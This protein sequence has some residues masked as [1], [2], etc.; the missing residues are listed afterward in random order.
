VIAMKTPA[1]TNGK[2]KDDLSEKIRDT[3]EE[4]LGLTKISEYE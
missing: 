2:V 4:E 1:L 3:K